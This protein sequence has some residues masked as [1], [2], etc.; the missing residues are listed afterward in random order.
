MRHGLTLVLCGYYIS[1]S[2]HKS[3]QIPPNTGPE[4]LLAANALTKAAAMKQKKVAAR[5]LL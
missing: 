2:Q 5:S 3:R 4:N 1:H